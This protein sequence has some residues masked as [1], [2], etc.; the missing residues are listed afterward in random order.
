MPS[1][2]VLRGPC[3]RGAAARGR[4]S[5]SRGPAP[6]SRGQVAI[7][8]SYDSCGMNNAYYPL[9]AAISHAIALL[10]R[11]VTSARPYRNFFWD[12]GPFVGKIPTRQGRRSAKYGASHFCSAKVRRRRYWAGKRKRRNTI[13]HQNHPDGSPPSGTAGHGALHRDPRGRGSTLRVPPFVAQHATQPGSAQLR[14]HAKTHSRGGCH[15]PMGSGDSLIHRLTAPG[16]C[17]GSLRRLTSQLRPI[18]QC[19]R[20]FT[21]KTI[22]DITSGTTQTRP[23]GLRRV[24]G[25]CTGIEFGGTG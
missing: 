3:R 7:A 2:P 11:S 22:A 18:Q 15:S 14:R 13:G 10:A 9:A 23:L 19:P 12:S 6:G 16:H 20:P 5:G 8:M 1:G 17:T 21:R 24:P 25:S 4:H